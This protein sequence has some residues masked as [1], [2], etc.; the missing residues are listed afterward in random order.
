MLIHEVAKS[1]SREVTKSR[2]REVAKSRSREVAKS[3]S[4]ESRCEVAKRKLHIVTSQLR[5]VVWLSIRS[6]SVII[7]ARWGD[8]TY[9]LLMTVAG[10]RHC[11]VRS[12]VDGGGWMTSPLWR[13]IVCWWRWLNEWL[14]I[15]TY[16]R[17]LMA[18]AE[19]R[20]HCDVRS[21]VDGGGWM[22]SSLWRTIVCWW[23]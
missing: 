6:F 22:T 12:P 9:Y 14:I 10:W 4:H 23:R 11:D 21:P 3:Q 7:L 2:S 15:V 19:W 16:D 13:T 5:P 18:V 20:H 1:R 8:R 17:L